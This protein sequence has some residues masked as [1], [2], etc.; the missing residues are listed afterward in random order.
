MLLP[1]LRR[2]PSDVPSRRGSGSRRRRLTA[3]LAA[4]ATG[5]AAA[6]AGG[7]LTAPAQAANRVTP[8]SFTGYGFDQCATQSQE[9]MDA[10]LHGSPFWAVGVYIAG[11]NRACQDPLTNQQHLTSEWVSTQLRNGWRILPVT[12]GPQA[13]CYDNPKKK[14]RI[15]DDPADNYAA[16]REQARL[17][18]RDTV[19][20]ARALGIAQRSTLWYDL[21]H[22][23][24]TGEPC[25]ESALH[26]LSTWTKVLHNLG[27]VSG[28]YSNASSGIK[29]LDDADASRPGTFTMPDAVWIARWNG[30]AT[31]E[32][33]DE[34]GNP[35]YIRPTSW[36]PHRR[37]HQYRGDHDETHGG[38]TVTIDSNYLSLGRGT[39]ARK[40]A[41]SC[42]VQVDFPR[43]RRL[44]RGQRHEQ[45]KAA[46]CVLR[47][48]RLYDGAMGAFFNLRTQRAVA[49]FQAAQGLRVTG[50][51]T[52]GTWTSLLSS[53]PAP[54]TK[55]GSGGNQVR[56]VQ[57]A[58]NAA[59]HAGLPVTGIFDAATTRAVR[60]YQ[61]ERG[62][63]RT[64]VVSVDTWSHLHRGLL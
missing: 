20:E 57:R 59:T 42:G 30:Q 45:V 24:I 29:M 12:V 6:V 64:G 55:I 10:W 15:E 36:M 22:F 44:V 9:V 48:K 8:G 18:A 49:R 31:V 27:Y 46:K 7:A 52:R 11:D 41:P 33:L 51:L 21:E 56:R 26:F 50:R 61:T 2:R 5:V 38:R 47:S 35:A 13:S 3:L 32:I 37:V 25:R 62:L 19:R 23:D 4:T 40:A 34:D 16:A 63:R 58:L 60:A 28:V 1:A 39:R 17:E 53:G 14:I 54:V 43:Y